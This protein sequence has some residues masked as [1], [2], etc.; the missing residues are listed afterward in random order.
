MICTIS[1]E[2]VIQDAPQSFINSLEHRLTFT[3]PEYVKKHH[4]GFW[5]GNTPKTIS[6]MWKAGNEVGIPFGCL[7]II[8]ENRD[9]F[10]NIVN[11][12]SRKIER[13][14][15]DSGIVLYDYQQEAVEAALKQKNGVII[16]PC[17]SGKTQMGLEI[18][19][20]IGGRTLWLTHTTDLLSQSMDRAKSVLGLPDDAYGTI[21]AGKVNIGK[22]MTFATVQTMSKM[23]LSIVRNAFDTVIVDEAHHCVGSP[24]RVQ[25]FYKVISALCARN[26]IGLTATPTRQDGLIGCMYALLGSEIYRVTPAQ[27]K[28][29]LCDVEVRF[30]D[31]G[32]E[33]DYNV[34]LASD[35]T[36]QYTSLINDMIADSDRNAKIVSDIKAARGRSLILSDRVSHVADI[37][38]MLGGR[39]IVL[40]GRVSKTE[41]EKAMEA[42]K[43]GEADCLVATYAI[44]R[45]GLDIPCL[46]NLF[47]VTPKKDYASVVQAAGR[48]ARKSDG[49]AQGN[50]YD[51]VDSFG[52]LRGWARKRSGFYKKAGYHIAF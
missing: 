2:I 18:A 46:D 17:G 37:A 52:M 49:K 11:L 1:N 4:M 26:K 40:T 8:G 10:C 34:V 24:A 12:V 19:A 5:T 48:V 7:P 36:L 51:Y 43:S 15:Y 20:R 3:N 6:L 39:T 25:M 33:P 27:V 35:G 22:V 21:T 45:E 9:K 44:A 23:N 30:V 29:N 50:V 16:A 38:Q 31:T 47:L 13:V 41:R 28:Q 42:I 14:D 32:Y